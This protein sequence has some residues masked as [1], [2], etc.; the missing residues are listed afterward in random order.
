MKKRKRLGIIFTA[1]FLAFVLACLALTASSYGY[2]PKDF[3]SWETIFGTQKSK[4]VSM[5]SASDSGD[6]SASSGESQVHFVDCGQGDCE[7]I[8]SNG[9]VTV[10]DAGP[11]SSAQKT[12]EYIKNLG[13]T[14]ID[15]LVLTHAHEDH[16]VGAKLLVE[17]F[18]IGKI[19]MS[20]PKSGTEPTTAVYRNLLTAI[21]SKGLKITTAKAGMTFESGDFNMKIISPST[22]YDELNNQSVVI[23]AVCGDTAFMFTGDA[24]KEPISDI[25]NNYPNDLKCDV[26]KVG[27][28]GSKTSTTAAWLKKL[29]AKYAVISCGDG[30]KY[31]HPHGAVLKLLNN[32]NVSVYRTDLSGSIVITTDGKTVSEPTVERTE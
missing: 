20:K 1:L 18:D 7:V 30:N 6:E 26:L 24:E 28:H 8:I 23:H 3:P 32:A 29:S 16:I 21:K 27:H 4:T 12:Y 5:S 25:M 17:N 11:Q 14:K 31:G 19:Y 15:N 9:A 10:I 22:D 13:V 2:L